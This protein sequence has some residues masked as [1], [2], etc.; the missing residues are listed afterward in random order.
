[1]EDG[2]YLQ[3]L[4]PELARVGRRQDVPPAWVIDGALYAWRT[5]FVRSERETWFNGRNLLRPVRGAG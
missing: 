5:S 2:S 3:H 1:V 4:V